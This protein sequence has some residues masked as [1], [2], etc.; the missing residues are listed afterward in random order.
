MLL[1]VACIVSWAGW[2]LGGGKGLALVVVMSSPLVALAVAPLV[3]SLLG[4]SVRAARQ[5]AYRDIEGR[6]FEYKGKSIRVQ[7]D[8]AG[9]RWLR[10]GDVR[11]V[12]VNLPRDQLLLRLAP[13]DLGQVDAKGDLFFRALALQKYLERNHDE[14]T[15]RFG[16]WL[17]REVVF[18]AQRASQRGLAPN[19]AREPIPPTA[20]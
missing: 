11:K 8:L 13:L 12:I 16:N 10:T 2:R 5:I 15:I 17:Q 20:P 1:L 3:V 9:E 7:E 18:P 14:P 4:F 19:S 6:Y